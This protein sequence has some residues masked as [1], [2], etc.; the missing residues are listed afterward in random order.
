MFKFAI[1]ASVLG[2]ALGFKSSPTFRMGSSLK[3][4][5]KDLVGGKL[6][7]RRIVLLFQ[8]K[9]IIQESYINLANFY[10]KFEW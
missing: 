1:I 6:Q 7:S 8:Q 9:Q 10:F 4:A 5:A 3:M 2:A